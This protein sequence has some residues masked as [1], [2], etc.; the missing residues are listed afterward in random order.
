MQITHTHAAGLDVHKKTVVACSFTPGPSAAMTNGGIAPI[1][2][3]RQLRWTT[4][5]LRMHV[6]ETR[7]WPGTRPGSRPCSPTI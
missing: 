5:A 7:S 2:T 3:C 4:W 6:G 1:H